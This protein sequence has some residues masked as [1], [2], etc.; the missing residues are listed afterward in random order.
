VP[1]I[2]ALT[3]WLHPCQA[4][5][6]VLT[7]QEYC[8]DLKGLKIAF[9]GDGNNVA[10]SL[11]FAAAKLGMKMVIATPPGYQLD[12]E[13]IQ[14]ANQITADT[15]TQ[16]NDPVRAVAKAD[17][18]YTDTWVSMG[19]EAEKQKRC[20]D[21]AAF[22]V[23][24]QLLKSAP[25]DAKIMHC[26][27][28]NRGLEITDEVVESPNSII[29]DQA[30]NRLHFQRALLK[31]KILVATTNP[32]KAAELEAMLDLDVDW[33]TLADFPNIPEVKEDG[34]TFIE[35]ARKKATGYAKAT[36]LWTI[37]D[38]SG[39]VIDALDGAPGIESARFSG[40]IGADR[41]L[42]DHKNIAKVLKLL[43]GVPTE[44]RTARFVCSLC[45]ACPDQILFET[46]GTLK[47]IITEKEIGKNGFG[48]DPIF[49]VP[50]LEK[51]V[52]KLT[53]EQKNAISHRGNA[54]RK[55]KPFLNK[56]LENT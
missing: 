40:Q 43:K 51:T 53:P 13:S 52:A 38:D 10:R 16:T 1:V 31:R 24:A 30:E 6:D 42:I 7:M 27:P 3:D 25:P 39:L 5:A 41:T 18:V 37:A 2:N 15:V 54:I 20:A 12:V 19:Q 47:G 22:Q 4:M 14:K 8:E 17:I 26:L 21:F 35:N 45:L 33:L 9:I 28:A 55:L 46:Q 29:L 32:G 23:N 11:A 34:T 44:K 56:L 49:F 36:G 50:H 48:Y